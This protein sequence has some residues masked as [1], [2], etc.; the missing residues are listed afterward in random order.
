MNDARILDCGHTP[1]KHNDCSTGTAHTA[2]G[3]EICWEC[4]AIADKQTM[5]AEGNSRNLPLYL[6]HD[7]FLHGSK[8]TLGKVTNWPSTLVFTCNVKKG[9]HNIAGSRY[10]VW[11]T[12]P[13]GKQWHGVQYGEWTQVCHCKQ[14]K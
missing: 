12:G 6:T 4:C 7:A 10:D 11:F 5:I 13:D 1:S 9:K 3:K 8:F 2:G 14:T